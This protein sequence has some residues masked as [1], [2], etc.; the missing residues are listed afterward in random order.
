MRYVETPLS[1]SLCKKGSAFQTSLYGLILSYE[2][3]P[4]EPQDLSH[5][6]FL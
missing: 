6:G 3:Y 1:S 4:T 2:Q 5:N